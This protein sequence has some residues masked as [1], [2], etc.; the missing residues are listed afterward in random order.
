MKRPPA[1]RKAF[2]AKGR[3]DADK[4]LGYIT[5]WKLRRPNL[6]PLW[7]RDAYTE[8][9]NAQRYGFHWMKRI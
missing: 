8:G 2:E 6:W 5:A 4:G 3:S 1:G 7:A 9:F